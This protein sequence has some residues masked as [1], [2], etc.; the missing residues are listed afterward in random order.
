[1]MLRVSKREPGVPI[2]EEASGGLAEALA[3]VEA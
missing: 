1:L 2:V 3:T